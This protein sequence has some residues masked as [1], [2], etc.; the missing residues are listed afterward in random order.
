MNHIC[1]RLYNLYSQPGYSRIIRILFYSTEALNPS[2]SE[3][4]GGSL[5]KRISPVGDPNASI[6]TVLNQWIEEGRT[7][8][9]RELQAMVKKLRVYRRFK[10]ALEVSQWMSD[11]RYFDLSPSDIAIRLD[12]IAKVHGLKQAEEYFDNIPK[13]LR[14]FSTYGALLNCYTHHKSVEKAEA[15]MQKMRDLGFATSSVTYNVLMNLYSQLGQ[16]EKVDILFQ[17]MEGK[18]ISP[19]KYSFSIRMS[20]YAATSSIDV[21]EKI[22]ERMEAD[23]QVVMDWNVYAVAA[24]GYI[25]AGLI[26]K[27]LEM[28]QKS[29]EL[30]TG[31][32]RRA[33][34]DFLLTLYA[35]TGKK[36]ELYRIWNQHKTS[37]K[38]YNSTYMCMIGSLLKLDDIEGT[39]KILAEWESGSTSYDFRVPNL[40]MV[41]YG[42]R[43]L[44]EKAEEF[45]NK[46]IERGMKPYPSTWDCLATAYLKD[47]QIPKAV[48]SMKNAILASRPGWKPNCSTLAA[49]LEYL[50]G[51]GDIEGIEEFTRLLRTQGTTPSSV[52]KEL[53]NN[54]EDGKLESDTL[55]QII[56]DA[57][58]DGKGGE[59]LK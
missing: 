45:I 24:N 36:D 56:K 32:R 14:I 38:V 43:G 6:V 46:A 28:L 44:W 35:S 52:C 34:V 16:H 20:A 48:E 33:A 37:E 27:A 1:S 42:N 19:D 40:L 2:I 54:V 26:D 15:H 12:L 50:K 3:I 11:R 51:Q 22:L 21:M 8:C 23:P 49:C 9:K 29:E 58:G 4:S 10:H 18:G 5:Y 17:E 7:L 41:A 39:E 30:V 59:S 55:G 25:K 31:K 13:H 53:Q 47:N 57:V